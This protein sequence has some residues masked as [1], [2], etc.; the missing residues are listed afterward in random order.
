MKEAGRGRGAQR[1]VP[2]LRGVRAI[3]A[4]DVSPGRVEPVGRVA[5]EAVV[6]P[7]LLVRHGPQ[8]HHRKNARAQGQSLAQGKSIALD[9]AE[10]QRVEET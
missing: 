6:C 10:R 3:G 8:R 2:G 9:C 1:Y 4:E 5:A 7:E